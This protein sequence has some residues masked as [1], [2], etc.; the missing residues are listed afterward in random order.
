MHRKQQTTKKKT[1]V[2][3]EDYSSRKRMSRGEESR[4]SDESSVEP[5]P[6]QRKPCKRPAGSHLDPDSPGKESSLVE[7]IIALWGYIQCGG[8]WQRC[9]ISI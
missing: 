4:V 9:S 8:V 3:A 2:F 6:T 1:G 5:H 7:E